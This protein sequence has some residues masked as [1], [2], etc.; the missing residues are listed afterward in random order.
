MLIVLQAASGLPVSMAQVIQHCRAPEDG[1]DDALLEVYLKAAIGYIENHCSIVLQTKEMQYLINAWPC[2]DIEIP[3]SPVRDVTKLEYLDDNGI[4]QEIDE[5]NW[6]WTRTADGALVTMA[7][8]YSLPELVQD[9][10][11]RVRVT[12]AAG[13]DDPNATG[14]GDDPADALPRQ[15]QVAAL[16]LPSFWY[17]Q[18]EPV[19]K[20]GG[21]KL[22]FGAEAILQQMR[23]FR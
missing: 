5:A 13:F 12:F 7:D 21:F 10:R 18:R 11:D 19:T 1:T 3:M 2:S 15:A 8:G 23:V 22:P 20:D 6:T 17:E 16:M 14:A 9:Q 4:L